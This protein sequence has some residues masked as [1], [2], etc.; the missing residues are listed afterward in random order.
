[1]SGEW[2]CLGYT[3]ANLGLTMGGWGG[4]VGERWEGRKGKKV[5]LERRAQRRGEGDG[6]VSLE[7]SEG[8]EG[9]TQRTR[10]HR[11]S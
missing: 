1:M 2:V 7:S 5:A 11:G 9:L 6:E 10:R 4:S 3:K 8:R